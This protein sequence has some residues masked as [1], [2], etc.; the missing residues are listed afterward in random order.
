VGQTDLV[1][2]GNQDSLVGLCVQDYKSLCAVATIY[3]TLIN[4]HHLD[5]FIWTDWAAAKNTQKSY[6]PTV[7]RVVT[8][9]AF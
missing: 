2:V 3:A 7:Q 5:Q 1:V 6:A 4:R 9:F 8:T